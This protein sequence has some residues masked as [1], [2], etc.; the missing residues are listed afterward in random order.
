MNQAVIDEI[1]K[2]YLDQVISMVTLFTP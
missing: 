1:K 2:H